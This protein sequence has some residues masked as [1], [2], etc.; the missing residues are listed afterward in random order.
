M[1]GVAQDL[2]QA[3]RQ[4]R[5]SPGF[6][7]VAVLTLGLGIG[8]NTAIFSMVDWL[9][10]R[11]LPI[12]DP[13][14]MTFL[15]FSG[16]VPNSEPQFSHPEF[17]EI[18]SQTSDVF[19]GMSAFIFGGLEGSQNSPNGLTFNGVTK[20]VQTVYVDGNFFPLLG[21]SP[22]IGRFVLPNEGM[23]AGSDP[24]VVLS[25]RYWQS[26]F[27]ADPSIL[28]KT[29]LINGHPVTVVG[30]APRG[31]LGITPL[32][33]TEA[34]LPLGMFSVERGVSSDF[35]VDA[36]VRN[37]IVFARMKP[38]EKVEQVQPALRVVGTRLLRR[39][40]R[41]GGNRELRAMKMRPPGLITGVNP[42]PKLAALFLSLAAMVLALACVN[43]A[44]LFLVRAGVRQREMA[45][46]SALGA[47]RGRLIRQL[48]TESLLLAGS[49][50]LAGV[51]LGLGGSRLLGHLPLQTELPLVL[52]FTFNW[53]VFTY[54]FLVALAT[55]IVV[56]IVPALRLS[57]GNL[58]EVLHE[59]G[60]TSTA[61]R[62]RMRSILVGLEVAGS[63]ALLI[64]AGLLLRSLNG[65]QRADLGFDP[66]S[67][68]NLTIDTNQVGYT[69]A[70]SEALYRGILERARTLP[71]VQS[72]SLASVVP[73]SDFG[74]S[75]DLEIPG[76]E[77][78][79]GQPAPQAEKNLVSS[80]YF[81]TMGMHLIRGREL[82]DADNENSARVAVI[83]LAMAERYWPGQD[84]VGKSFA[85]SDDK[86]HP[87]TIVGLV[88]NS[89]MSQLYGPYD[90]LFYLPSA[91]YYAPVQTLQVRTQQ[92][93]QTMLREI[94]EMVHS[95]APALPVYGMRTMKDAL[96]GINGLLLFE[97]GAG[98][99]AALGS[100]GLILAIVGVYG[101]MSYSVGQ[102][103][104]EIGVRMAMGAQPRDIFRIVGGQ[105]LLIVACGLLFGLLAASAAALLVGDFLVEVTPHDPVTYVS[106]SLLLASVALIAVYIPARRAVRVDPMVALRYE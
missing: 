5:K 21:I 30:V 70:Q 95:I 3:L 49:G 32:V 85:M 19:S 22:H 24:V 9:V 26:R 51:L 71:G 79:K 65:V 38:G 7:S 97:I 20:P 16:E 27:A 31:F 43:V 1:R 76:Y 86:V 11:S 34:Y 67:V 68:L 90:L 91:Q 89:R 14:Q 6:F 50:C 77:V 82:N 59:G 96:Q 54:A 102:R 73:L 36:R 35:M 28:G 74:L 105:G 62:Q 39:Y 18:R 93:P 106:L 64:V 61:G 40:P 98:L 88:K 101:V 4:F 69:E 83:N 103:T 10:L 44:N 45:V 52:D 94:Q 8:A 15:V 29:A 37:T 13:G 60:R 75:N 47:A 53:R 81:E 57:R 100:L 56:G 84:P 87:V 46:R 48:L 80:D 58:R 23:A 42:L 78:A 55:G 72:A 25:Y 99:A 12:K 2:R 66:Q 63:L 104:Q 17:T 33:D 92:A 41:D